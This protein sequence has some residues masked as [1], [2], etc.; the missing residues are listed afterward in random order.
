MSWRSVHLE[1]GRWLPFRL[2]AAPLAPLLLTD[3]PSPPGTSHSPTLARVHKARQFYLPKGKLRGQMLTW[4]RGAPGR[5]R[6]PREPALHSC[7]AYLELGRL[8]CTVPRPATAVAHCSFTIVSSPAP[9]RRSPTAGDQR[10]VLF[11][12]AT[13]SQRRSLQVAFQ[14]PNS[15]KGRWQAA[16]PKAAL[17]VNIDVN[18][19]CMQLARRDSPAWRTPSS[20]GAA[21][22]WTSAQQQRAAMPTSSPF[23]SL[24]PLFGRRDAPTE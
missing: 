6:R 3:V 20:A 24:L 7:Y 4:Q 13:D 21:A 2:P 19:V 14:L 1:T 22:V 8:Q 12:F 10:V 9:E 11:K 15:T 5:L 16:C 23:P 18:S 17:A